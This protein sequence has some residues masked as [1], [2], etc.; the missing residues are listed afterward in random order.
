PT[1]PCKRW[2]SAAWAT[3]SS[4]GADSPTILLPPA[5]PG[6]ESPH[7]L[8]Q[9][10]V[11]AGAVAAREAPD[12]GAGRHRPHRRAVVLGAHQAEPT[13]GRAPPARRAARAPAAHRALGAGP[14]RAKRAALEPGGGAARGGPGTTGG[15]RR[16]R[17]QRHPQPTVAGRE[18]RRSHPHVAS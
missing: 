12:Q 10:L 15:V 4:C 1:S 6:P 13:G 9:L 11:A 2:W 8:L 3:T 14:D 17:A 16:I 18:R 7:D 5:A